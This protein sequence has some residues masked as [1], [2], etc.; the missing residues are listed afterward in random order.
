MDYSQKIGLTHYGPSPCIF[1]PYSFV[2]VSGKH[3]F[4]DCK[5]LKLP[6]IES[7]TI[8]VVWK[9]PLSDIAVLLYNNIAVL[10]F[11]NISVLLFNNISVLLFNNIAVLLFSN[12]A[13]VKCKLGF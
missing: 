1:N 13:V 3:K 7:V 4:Y 9:H 11:Y 5:I 12:I 6:Y 10:L 2:Y 8:H